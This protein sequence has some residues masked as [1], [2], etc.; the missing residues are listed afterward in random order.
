MGRRH[1]AVPHFD[2]MARHGPPAPR[3]DDVDDDEEPVGSGP[4]QRRPGSSATRTRRVR[5]ES[6][7]FC[8]PAAS[9]LSGDSQTR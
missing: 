7:S 5:S 3:K 6:R 8:R 2:A 9:K 4:P 1:M